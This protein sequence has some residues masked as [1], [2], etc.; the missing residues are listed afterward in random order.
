MGLRIRDLKAGGRYL[1]NN[2]NFVRI[3]DCIVGNT[4]Y[5]HDDCGPGE[6][7]CQV[8]LK[9]C[10][11]LAPDIEHEPEAPKTHEK[12]ESMTQEERAEMQELRTAII[13]LSSVVMGL[14]KMTATTTRLVLP[15]ADHLDD[16]EKQ[17]VTEAL[18]GL[19]DATG[20]IQDQLGQ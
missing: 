1:H 3:I 18:A 10:S 9:R 12:E 11:G 2:G 14:A 17:A 7:S 20:Q 15:L 5:W 19:S 16:E 6:C 4:V 13:K 8:F